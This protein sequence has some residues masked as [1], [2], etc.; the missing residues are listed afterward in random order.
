MKNSII[1]IVLN[2]LTKVMKV[3][4]NKDKNM[5]ELVDNLSYP[6]I[7]NIKVLG[8]NINKIIRISKIG[9]NNK[10]KEIYENIDIVFKNIDTAYKV[11][12]ARKSMKQCYID[13]MITAEGNVSDCVC[14]MEMVNLAENYLLPTRICKKILDSIPN[15]SVSKIKILLKVIL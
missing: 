13:K 15:L 11:V 5:R 12:T 3:V 4:F 6:I 8:T 10:N 14:I 1:K 9:I 7:L 2:I